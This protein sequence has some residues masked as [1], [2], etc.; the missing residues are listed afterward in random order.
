[1]TKNSAKIPAW[2]RIFL[3]AGKFI[4]P[5]SRC[6][7]YCSAVLQQAEYCCTLVLLVCCTV[8]NH[9]G[10]FRNEPDWDEGD[11]D[12]YEVHKL[13]ILQYPRTEPLC[14]EPEIRLEMGNFRN[15][16][17]TDNIFANDRESPKCAW[18]LRETGKGIPAI[19]NE[20]ETWDYCCVFTKWGRGLNIRKN[21]SQINDSGEIDRSGCWQ[22]LLGF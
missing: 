7:N 17:R 19:T 10:L 3:F 18:D 5:F 12:T 11:I 21:T 1:M 22:L 15:D 8:V 13:L 9:I 6:Q 16:E 2:V 4:A 14:G 20:H